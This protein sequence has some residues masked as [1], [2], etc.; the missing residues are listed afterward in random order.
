[1]SQVGYD[2]SMDLKGS[3]GFRREKPGSAIRVMEV[4]FF[5]RRFDQLWEKWSGGEIAVVRDSTYLNWRYLNCPAADYRVFTAEER[6]KLLGY[7]V[8]K[9]FNRGWIRCGNIADLLAAPDDKIAGA[10]LSAAIRHLAKSGA[11][12]V[13]AWVPYH[14][15]SS[16]LFR[17]MGFFSFPSWVHFAARSRRDGD[18][19][20]PCLE[21][22]RN[23]HY[24][25]G[26][27]DYFPAIRRLNWK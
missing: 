16:Q 9:T 18:I 23:W 26:D 27:K 4:R 17:R 24:T 19:P 14:S 3:V 11:V 20:Q 15:P 12:I 6:G 25:I 13:I 7:V 1:M 2:S 22:E 10:L 5:D 21:D 8:L